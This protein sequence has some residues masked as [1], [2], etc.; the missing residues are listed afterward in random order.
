MEMGELE[1]LLFEMM[2]DVLSLSVTDV[3]WT[4]ALSSE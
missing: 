1:C 4:S 3:R 2:M